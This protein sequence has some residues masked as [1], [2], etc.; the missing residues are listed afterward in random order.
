M[1]YLY[2]VIS[3]SQLVA[4]FSIKILIC[5]VQT[6]NGQICRAV[7]QWKHLFCILI[8]FCV[9]SMLFMYYITILDCSL[10]WVWLAPLIQVLYNSLYLRCNLV[11]PS[12]KSNSWRIELNHWVTSARLSLLL[13][14][15][16]TLLPLL[17]Q[18][19]SIPSY[20]IGQIYS[21]DLIIAIVSWLEVLSSFLVSAYCRTGNFY[22]N[23]SY[24]KVRDAVV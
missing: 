1:I 10:K 13:S 11:K 4:T 19:Y 8:Y 9:M 6:R 14:F 12:M 3:L 23:H 21:N 16:R 24:F 5:K 17:S 20:N 15:K 22:R 2:S 18:T 7:K